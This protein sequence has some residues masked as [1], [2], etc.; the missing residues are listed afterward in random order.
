MPLGC[1]ISPDSKRR[2]KRREASKSDASTDMRRETRT[3]S[4]PAVL[5]GW[6]WIA[7]F[8]YA[9]LICASPAPRGTPSTW[10]TN[11]SSLRSSC[12]QLRQNISTMLD[13]SSQA[14][15][16]KENMPYQVSQP[17]VSAR[18]TPSMCIPCKG[19]LASPCCWPMP[20]SISSHRLV[21]LFNK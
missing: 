9:L 19:L 2:G 7:S 20:S 21:Q 14:T 10:K 4:S 1:L 11:T 18:R 5:S 6:Y 13:R 16:R 3:S 12:S 8:L 15:K 17:T